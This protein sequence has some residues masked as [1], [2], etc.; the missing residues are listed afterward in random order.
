MR[1]SSRRQTAAL[2][3]VDQGCFSG[4]SLADASPGLGIRLRCAAPTAIWSFAMSFSLRGGGV[5]SPVFGRPSLGRPSFVPFDMSPGLQGGAR[6][7]CQFMSMCTRWRL[8]KFNVVRMYSTKRGDYV[9]WA[10]LP[11]SFARAATA[12]ETGRA[13]WAWRFSPE[14][15]R[16]VEHSFVCSLG[17]LDIARKADKRD[18]VETSKRTI[19][20]VF[21]LQ[22]MG[23]WQSLSNCTCWPV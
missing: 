1:L 23:L 4:D 6:E 20:G 11:P 13:A 9:L 14:D 21:V 7:K 18:K 2:T 12:D 5:A 10:R 17:P 3:G 16:P 8:T 19:G 15:S 22:N